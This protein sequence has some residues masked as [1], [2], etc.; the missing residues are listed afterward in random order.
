ML[1]E[2]QR[3][4]VWE[5]V[6]QLQALAEGTSRGS[7]EGTH[8]AF[9]LAQDG[10][11]DMLPLLDAC[12]SRD[13]FVQTHGPEFA[14]EMT[15]LM[16]CSALR[17]AEAL[18]WLLSQ[19]RA[20]LAEGTFKRYVE[21]E[22]HWG[23]NAAYFL[24]WDRADYGKAGDLMQALVGTGMDLASC[25]DMLTRDG[26]RVLS[27]NQ[28]A[29]DNAEYRAA[30]QALTHS[31]GYRRRA[32]AASRSQQGDEGQQQPVRDLARIHANAV[33]EARKAADQMFE[34]ARGF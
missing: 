14:P 21:A 31:P 25:A 17:D 29:T 11:T 15:L 30:R 27:T 22:D 13:V 4:N 34:E 32:G 3:S 33:R 8:I 9:T 24:L 2:E 12:G 16:H 5:R 23:H 6:L 19:A 20:R 18:K 1:P 26:A 28:R 10:F 7:Q